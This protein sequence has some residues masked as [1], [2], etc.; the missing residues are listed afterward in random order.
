MKHH[1]ISNR[2]SKNGF[3]L[4]ELVIVLAVMAILVT[5]G[6]PSLTESIKNNRMV[7][8][9]N[10]MV[11]MLQ[12]ARSEAIRRNTDVQVHLGDD[13][14]DWEAFIKDPDFTADVEGCVLG[15]LRCAENEN[16]TMNYGLDVVDEGINVI[17]FNNRGYIR[18]L[19]E[20]WTAEALFLEHDNCNGNNQ[21]R[22]IDIMPTGQISSCSLACGSDEC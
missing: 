15:Q 6:F 9:N 8:Q 2:N 20:P 19:G 7:A 12:Y 4:I 18:D 21:R 13:G 16:V 22:R 17:T 1:H 5:W 10:E 14:S 3:T 11:A